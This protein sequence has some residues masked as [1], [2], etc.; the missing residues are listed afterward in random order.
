MITFLKMFQIASNI[1][2][3]PYTTFQSVKV[4]SKKGEHR[5]KQQGEM[6]RE[7]PFDR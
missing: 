3:F 7:L 6:K 2:P 1:D 4:R 5:S